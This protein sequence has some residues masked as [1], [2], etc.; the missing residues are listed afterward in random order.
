MK[1]GAIGVIAGLTMTVPS[2]NGANP[3]RNL[4]KNS[5]GKEVEL[6]TARGCFRLQEKQTRGKRNSRSDTKPCLESLSVLKIQ[7]G[8]C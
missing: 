6:K 3:G 1:S 5:S 4:R 2:T 8:L 7:K